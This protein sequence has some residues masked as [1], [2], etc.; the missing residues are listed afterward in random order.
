MVSAEP[1][2]ET[3][4]VMEDGTYGD[5]REISPG[6]DSALA[7]KGGLKVA[8]RSADAPMSRSVRVDDKGKLLDEQPK[9]AEAEAGKKT[10]EMKPE[11]ASPPKA[12][13]PYK[14]R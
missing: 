8:M 6:K 2:Y 12:K 7:S 13:K 9:P 4:Y 1:I 14:T 11:A 5:P 3:W 10:T